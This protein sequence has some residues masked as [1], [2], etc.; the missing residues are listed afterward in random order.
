[1]H[2]AAKVGAATAASLAA[3][4][5]T[6]GAALVVGAASAARLETDAAVAA[7]AVTEVGTTTGIRAAAKA[8]IERVREVGVVCHLGPPRMWKNYVPHIEL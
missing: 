1:M 7:A 5:E 6:V 8:D 2:A 4:V 3:R